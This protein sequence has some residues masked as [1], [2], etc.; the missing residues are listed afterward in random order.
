MDCTDLFIRVAERA[1]AFTRSLISLEAWNTTSSHLPTGDVHNILGSHAVS[2]NESFHHSTMKGSTYSLL[3]A[4]SYVNVIYAW[5][6]STVKRISLSSI[7]SAALP[8]KM[9]NLSMD[10]EQH[11]GGKTFRIEIP[12]V[13]Q[14]LEI[15]RQH[16]SFHTEKLAE[17]DKVAAAKG[18]PWQSS[19]DP[20]YR[21][22]ADGSNKP[23]YLS[24]WEW[25]LDYMKEHLTNLN[26][27]PVE[28]RQGR[29]LS[30]IDNGKVR[31]HTFQCS[32][33]E[34]KC[35]RMTVMDGGS[36]SQVFTSLWYPSPN[37]SLPV[38]GVDLL[39]F[40]QSKHLCIVDFQP[41]HDREDE[42]SHE[43]QFEH[44]LKPI[45][46]QYPSL[47]GKMTK[48]FY[49]EDSFFSKQMLLGRCER[50][51]ANDLVF[52]DLFPAYKAYVNSHVK[53]VQSA[54]P[55][56]FA[57]SDV[58]RRHAAYDTYSAARDPAHGMLSSTFGKDFADDYVYDILFPLSD[59][60]ANGPPKSC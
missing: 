24:F 43:Q 2:L 36:R 8:P 1:L 25:Q 11:S 47:H 44:L 29:D 51:G 49:D 32:S 13:S 41:I 6:G 17:M 54:T 59:R 30:Y 52:K 16:R 18:M 53:M 19:I 46:D 55:S 3:F 60:G 20:N 38:L 56:K 26:V 45:R 22:L 57:I 34:Y 35:I 37:Y 40:G 23:F 14:S 7:K 10:I 15:P 39:Q 12:G 9:R 48:R 31:L 33:D 42:A 50:E 27:V 4:L 5:G 21:S 58:L 28:S